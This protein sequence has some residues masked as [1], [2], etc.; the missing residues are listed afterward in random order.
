MISKHRQT[1]RQEAGRLTDR[2][3]PP[4]KKKK[5]KIKIG[6][7]ISDSYVKAVIRKK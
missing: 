6:Y 7:L 1:R 3:P 2:P 5:S 4:K